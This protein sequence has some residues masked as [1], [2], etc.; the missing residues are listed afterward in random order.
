MKEEICAAAK[1]FA[2][3]LE[4]SEK[5]PREQ[6]SN[7]EKHL[8]DLLIERFEKHWFPDLPSKGQGYRCIR[9]NGIT[10]VDLTLETAASK[11]GLRY[12][13]L[14]LPT[15]LTVWVDPTEVCYRLG[16]SEGSYCTLAS[17][18][19]SD[20]SS[21]SSSNPSST[22]SS[23]RPLSPS[24]SS[25]PRSPALSPSPPQVVP[26]MDRPAVGRRQVHAHRQNNGQLM[27]R[28]PPSGGAYQGFAEYN[29][30]QAMGKFRNQGFV[31]GNGGGR[32]T[33]QSPREMNF[34]TFNHPHHRPMYP[35]CDGPPFP[36][37]PPFYRNMNYN[38]NYH[39][40]V[41]RV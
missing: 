3:F 35:R 38:R 5:V 10:P 13:D 12:K 19:H 27:G 6:L 9:V 22:S 18:P 8:T 36:M 2:C 1:F 14:R 24:F 4:K 31:A 34:N 25:S 30:P 20:A 39:K 21:L 11:S 33:R 40:N 17:F 37:A 23:P 26:L 28:S 29:S 7:F 16:E 41:L 32:Q 15:E